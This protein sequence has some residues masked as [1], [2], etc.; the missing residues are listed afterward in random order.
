MLK[1]CLVDQLLCAV[2]NVDVIVIIN[3]IVVNIVNVTI[4]IGF[5]IAIV[6]TIT[7]NI[8]AN[9]NSSVVILS[10]IVV[11]IFS[12]I[13]SLATRH[14][15]AYFNSVSNQYPYC[16]LSEGNSKSD[17]RKKRKQSLSF[18]PFTCAIIASECNEFPILTSFLFWRPLSL[19]PGRPRKKKRTAIQHMYQKKE[20]QPTTTKAHEL[21]PVSN[22]LLS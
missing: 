12:V 14:G 19:T 17:P 3:V 10:Y 18:S 22:L 8:I 1:Y 9:I 4:I 20:M 2:L 7:I 5:V 11:V 6:I 15:S 16:Y 21:A 13:F